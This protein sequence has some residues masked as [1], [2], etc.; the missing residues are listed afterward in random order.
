MPRRYAAPALIQINAAHLMQDHAA[1]DE[2]I[3][4]QGA[5][6]GTH[7]LVD[8][9]IHLPFRI[10][11]CIAADQCSSVHGPASDDV[12]RPYFW[13]NPLCAPTL[14]MLFTNHHVFCTGAH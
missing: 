4:F 11:G 1:E 14:A 8:A 13:A 7:S 5:G 2:P 10:T 6:D 3:V 9:A 12:S